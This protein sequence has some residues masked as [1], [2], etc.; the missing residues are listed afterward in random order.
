VIGQCIGLCVICDCPAAFE[1]GNHGLPENGF[2]QDQPITEAVELSDEAVEEAVG[3]SVLMD[4]DSG[5]WTQN[6]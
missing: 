3:S 6:C 1:S 2:E 5:H 4:I